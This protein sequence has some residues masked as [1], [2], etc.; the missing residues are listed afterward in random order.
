MGSERRRTSASPWSALVGG[1]RA[2]AVF[3][4]DADGVIDSWNEGVRE[5]LGFEEEEFVG[6][7]GTI[8]FTPEDNARG[9]AASELAA[10]RLNGEAMDDRWHVRKDGS[11]LWVNGI[12]HAV[13]D[14][15]GEVVGFL[16]IM[17][18]QTEKLHAEVRLEEQRDLLSA[19]IDS[20]PGVFYMFDEDGLKLWNRELE[21]VTGFSANELRAAT[22]EDLLV[23]AG[24][25]PEHLEE[26]RRVGNLSVELELRTKGGPGIPYLFTSQRVVLDDAPLVLGLG[27]EMADQVEGRQ[28]LERFALEQA[29]VAELAA[30]TLTTA[31]TQAV[32]DLATRRVAETLEAAH[33][34]IVEFAPG[35]EQEEAS[36]AAEPG[37]EPEGEPPELL[38]AEHPGDDSASGSGDVL[39]LPEA[40]LA[41]FGLR[42]GVRTYIRGPKRLFGFVEVLSERENAFSSDDIT[43]LQSVAF[44]LAGA[45]ETQRLHRE[46]ERRAETDDLTG[47]LNRMAFEH[48]LIAALGRAERQGT[49]V[50]VLFV[51]LDK[52]K[53]VNDTYGHQ[54]GDEVLE[55]AAQRLR[56]T[57]RSWDVVGRH[58]GDEFVL[59]LPDVR[60]RDEVVH[61]AERLL[62]AF[63]SPFTAAGRD[64]HIGATIGISLYPE[65][66][67]DSDRLLI[68]A[69]DALYRG[70]AEG[71]HSFHFFRS[72]RGAD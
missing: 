10:A 30:Y 24:Q 3:T 48:R 29:A 25:L 19:V 21:R 37:R 59:F 50:A 69:D 43:F 66:G 44:L 70:K 36:V 7:P 20:L 53:T 65:D 64:H 18:D 2:Y 47:L 14:G 60:S 26:I 67:T 1:L 15:A 40:E 68:C 4:M 57:V 12:V 61:V 38:G 45:L 55:Q 5:L 72:E 52:F 62:K 22:S 35:T 41:P 8:I 54:A 16:K 58:G 33:V 17:R 31:D 56:E 27:I 23:D 49:S 9:A 46:L 63:S 6:R 42:S 51:D 11:R 39:E 13:S 32:L 71:R 34:R 28:L